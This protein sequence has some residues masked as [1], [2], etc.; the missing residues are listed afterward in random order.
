MAAHNCSFFMLSTVKYIT[1]A[2]QYEIVVFDCASCRWYSDFSLISLWIIQENGTL[3]GSSLYVIRALCILLFA[4]I[5]AVV[6]QGGRGHG[7][8]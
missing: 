4:G 5:V 7:F 8:Y 1:S 3:K 6:D 2:S